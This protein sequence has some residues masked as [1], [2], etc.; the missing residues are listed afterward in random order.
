MSGCRHGIFPILED[1]F[2]PSK[3]FQILYLFDPLEFQIAEVSL[4]NR[5]YYSQREFVSSSQ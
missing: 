1:R 2:S 3:V 4:I 5:N